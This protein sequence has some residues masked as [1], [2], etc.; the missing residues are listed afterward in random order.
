SRNS[1]Y[2]LYRRLFRAA[3]ARSRAIAAGRKLAPT[4]PVLLKLSVFGEHDVAAQL[5]VFALS[6]EILGRHRGVGNLDKGGAGVGGGQLDAA[7]LEILNRAG[8]HGAAED[9][10][11][12]DLDHQRRGEVADSDV[13]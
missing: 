8:Q 5:A 7:A 13:D 1:Y 3:A 4:P 2:Q 6:A 10:F 9:L 12:V 11:A